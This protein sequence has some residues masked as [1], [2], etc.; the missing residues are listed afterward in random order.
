MK[1]VL[2]SDRCGRTRSVARLYFGKPSGKWLNINCLQR[3]NIL[4]GKGV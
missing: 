4:S 3:G 2:C 1:V